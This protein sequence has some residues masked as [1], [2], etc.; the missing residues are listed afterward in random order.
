[1]LGYW[2]DRALFPYAR[3]TRSALPINHGQDFAGQ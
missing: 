2:I 1:M 3:P